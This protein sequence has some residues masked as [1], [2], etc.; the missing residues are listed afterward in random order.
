MPL[1]SCANFSPSPIISATSRWP[2][3]HTRSP[4][5]FLLLSPV[6]AHALAFAVIF[7]A[8]LREL[9]TGTKRNFICQ[10][11]SGSFST[12]TSHRPEE[13][14]NICC[15]SSVRNDKRLILLV[16]SRSRLEF[17]M[18]FYMCILH[19]VNTRKRELHRPPIYF[20]VFI[21]LW[22]KPKSC[23]EA[24]NLTPSTVFISIMTTLFS[25]I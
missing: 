21:T 15:V 22:E 5:F 11:Y 3:P 8:V 18:W 13:G 25:S 14:R 2:R 1:W 6:L 17:C 9:P 20:R 16:T 12:F 23:L 24:S 10:I 7:Q 4:A 19:D